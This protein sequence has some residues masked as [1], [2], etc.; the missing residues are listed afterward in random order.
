MQPAPSR[1]QS[2]NG[3]TLELST[4]SLNQTQG[5]P[6]AGRAGMGFAGPHAGPLILM[7]TPSL[8]RER[9]STQL[10]GDTRSPPRPSPSCQEPR[11]RLSPQ[12]LSSLMLHFPAPDFSFCPFCFYGTKIER[13]SKMARK[14]RRPPSRVQGWKRAFLGGA[15]PGFVLSLLKKKALAAPSLP[16][17]L[18]RAFC[19]QTP[20]LIK[21]EEVT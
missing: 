2:P 13:K 12:V 5:P 7:L 10:W 14:K 4:V 11:L 20:L 6:C 19:L 16:Q 17:Q 18:R 1:P 8:H 21:A 3:A 9:G 15:K